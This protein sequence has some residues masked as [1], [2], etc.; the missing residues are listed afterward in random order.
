MNEAHK[1][2]PYKL[3]SNIEQFIIGQKTA[4]PVLSCR[5]L[6][7][8]VEAYFQVA[9]SK[10]LINNVLKHSELSSVVGRRRIKQKLQ[11]AQPSVAKKAAENESPKSLLGHIDFI[12]NGGYFFLK[13]ALLKACLIPRI[14]GFL[15]KYYEDLHRDLL[16]ALIEGYIFVS[17]LNKTNDLQYFVGREF[18]LV[19]MEEFVEKLNNMPCEELNSL[20]IQ[21]DHNY[22]LNNMKELGERSICYLNSFAQANFFPE[23]YKKTTISEM[24]V[25]FYALRASIKKSPN[26]LEIQLL[27]PE[28]FPY[29]K[30]ADWQE[31]LD[32]QM[33]YPNGFPTKNDIV[34]QQALLHAVNM[35]NESQI[36]TLDQA[37]VR[38][39]P[40][41]SVL[42]PT[43]TDSSN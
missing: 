32:I 28:D 25:R 9:I 4:D 37:Q 43:T 20:F 40:N 1:R 6:V 7:P 10:S 34:W 42:H 16:E 2:K 12:E 19:Q 3:K 5:D 39:N 35:V 30:Q 36:L 11:L 17:I 27:Y 21:L 8:L 18:N 33:L 26:L 13:A 29:R 22:K 15:S 23:S 41:I 38:F 31:D 14:A 24:K